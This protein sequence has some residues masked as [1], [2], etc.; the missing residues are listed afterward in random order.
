MN[1][2][3]FHQEQQ[4]GNYPNGRFANRNS[5]A[6]NNVILEISPF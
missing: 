5:S 4:N 1:I 6:Q 3:T 2:P